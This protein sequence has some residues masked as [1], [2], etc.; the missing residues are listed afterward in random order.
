MITYEHDT[1][2]ERPKHQNLII[3][4]LSRRQPQVIYVLCSTAYALVLKADLLHFDFYLF[5]LADILYT[6]SY[7]YC[8]KVG[9]ACKSSTNIGL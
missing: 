1:F 3:G 9:N 6:Y 8:K 7:R 2:I 5:P 4:V